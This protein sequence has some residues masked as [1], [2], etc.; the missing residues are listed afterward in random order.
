MLKCCSNAP[1][2]ETSMEVRFF[3][4]LPCAAILSMEAEVPVVES[5]SASHF[6]S[7]GISLHMFLKLS[8]RASNLK[9]GGAFMSV[10]SYYFK[11]NVGKKSIIKQTK[12]IDIL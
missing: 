6:F 3:R 12:F 9:G 7:S 1:L 4:F 2:I 10:V 11:V 8:C 5:A